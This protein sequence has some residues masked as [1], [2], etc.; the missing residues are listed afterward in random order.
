MTEAAPNGTITARRRGALLTNQGLK[1]DVAVR[2]HDG[3]STTR[4]SSI[5]PASD[6]VVVALA[7]CRNRRIAAA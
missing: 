3:T 7:V 1:S 2:R 4:I 5:A 6:P